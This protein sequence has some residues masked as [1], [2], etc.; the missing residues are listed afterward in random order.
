MDSN[1][2]S[3]L[4]V[5]T[6]LSVL[7]YLLGEGMKDHEIT[8]CSGQPGPLESILSNSFIVQTEKLEPQMWSDLSEAVSMAI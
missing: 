8:D 6:Q 1:F 2:T 3:T 7:E 5:G 4:A